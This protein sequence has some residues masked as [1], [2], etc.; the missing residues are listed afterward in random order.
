MRDITTKPSPNTTPTSFFPAASAGAT[1][2]FTYKAVDGYVDAAANI[3][4]VT[5]ENAATVRITL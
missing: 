5:C 2:T 1:V 3:N 4:G